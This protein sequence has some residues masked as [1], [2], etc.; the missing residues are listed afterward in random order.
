M[1]DPIKKGVDLHIHTKASDGKLTPEELVAYAEKCNLGVIAVTDHNTYSPEVEALKASSSVTIITG[2]E[3]NAHFRFRTGRSKLIHIKGLFFDYLHPEIQAIFQRERECKRNFVKALISRLNGTECIPLAHL[4][5]NP[6]GAS[7]ETP[8][9][10]HITYEEFEQLFPD[11]VSPGRV[12]VGEL[13][14][15]K[16]YVSNV[17]EALDIYFGELGEKR[18]YVNPMDYTASISMEDCIRAIRNAKGMADLAHPYFYQLTESEL[19]ELLFAFKQYA[20]DT[21]CMEV[22]Y[23]DY[24]RKQEEELF[25][26]AE[27]YGLLPSC[28]SDYHGFDPKEALISYPWSIYKNIA[29]RYKEVYTSERSVP[30][31]GA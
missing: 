8:G 13:M 19:H 12:H 24:S 17:Y 29:Q 27:E 25:S 20:G 28:G 7:S 18:C 3:F 16:G 2:C 15:R 22:Y 31:E 23:K 10:I 26:L 21:G 4:S 30:S 1:A 5:G 9:R 11:T 6:E 14:R